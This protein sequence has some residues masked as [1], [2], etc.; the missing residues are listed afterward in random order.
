MGSIFVPFGHI[1]DQKCTCI[2]NPQ[3]LGRAKPRTNEQSSARAYLRKGLM[4][5]KYKAAR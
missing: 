4:T 5:N 2:R 1:L 3:L